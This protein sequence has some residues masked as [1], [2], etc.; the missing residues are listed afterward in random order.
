MT[1]LPAIKK[2]QKV[3]RAR[4]ELR[5]TKCTSGIVHWRHKR[6]WDRDAV[7][8]LT[9]S[10]EGRSREYRWPGHYRPW[11]AVEATSKSPLGYEIAEVIARTDKT[12]QEKLNRRGE[13][14]GTPVQ[15]LVLDPKVAFALAVKAKP[16]AVK[17][18]GRSV[19]PKVQAPTPP[20]PLSPSTRP[21][22]THSWP[23]PRPSR[24]VPGPK[25]RLQ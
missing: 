1:L 3:G 24:P 4:S 8:R 11:D 23:P 7:Q 15:P 22:G 25:N 5:P 14:E 19:G 13:W 20:P 9:W 18:R 6:V 10:R 17:P 2:P 16:G 21:R 12:Y